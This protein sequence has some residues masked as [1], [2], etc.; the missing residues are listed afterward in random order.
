M[1]ETL[2][3]KENPLRL[4]PADLM[5]NKVAIYALSRHLDE[6]LA[7]FT[8]KRM[9]RLPVLDEERAVGIVSIG[10]AVKQYIADKEFTIQQLKNYITGS[11]QD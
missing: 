11:I 2:Y 6:C 7:L 8:E 9:H 1:Q 4:Y 5:N 10:D 3:W